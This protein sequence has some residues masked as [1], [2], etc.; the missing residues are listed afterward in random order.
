MDAD[1]QPSSHAVLVG[2]VRLSTE[3]KFRPVGKT[4]RRPRDG[5]PDGPGGTNL[6]SSAVISAL[7]SDRPQL[8]TEGRMFMRT[9]SRTALVISPGGSALPSIT[10]AARSSSR[11]TVSPAVRQGS[12]QTRSR[13]SG[14]RA[15][16][17]P[18]MSQSSGSNSSDKPISKASA[19]VSEAS[20][21]QFAPRGT[22]TSDA[23]KSRSK[24]PS[25]A[26]PKTCRP[27]R[28]WLSLISHK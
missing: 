12:A 20:S 7:I 26:S 3:K 22:R 27:S 23:T 14:L 9:F 18:D 24:D 6:P 16:H 4:S 10:A 21:S 17:L 28:I 8:R 11:S 1:F 5:A 13:I 2:R 15:V 25:G 19:L